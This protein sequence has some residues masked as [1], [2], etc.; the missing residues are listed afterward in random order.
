MS[1]ITIYQHHSLK[2]LV[3]HDM[4]HIIKPLVFDISY[5]MGHLG[6]KPKRMLCYL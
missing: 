2:L 1:D 3:G 5:I 6:K 4:Y